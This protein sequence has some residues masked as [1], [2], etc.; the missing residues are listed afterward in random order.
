MSGAAISRGQRN[1]LIMSSDFEAARVASL[2][3]LAATAEAR[4]AGRA[5][6]SATGL[7]L[8]DSGAGELEGIRAAA[9]IA[10][11]PGGTHRLAWTTG[12]PVSR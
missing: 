8:P 5:G 3:A 2:W 7:I 10:I 6:G 11:D 1:S 9:Q 12:S 4:H